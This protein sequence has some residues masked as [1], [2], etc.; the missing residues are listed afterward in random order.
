M[1]KPKQTIAERRYDYNKYIRSA[2][3]ANIKTALLKIRGNACQRCGRRPLRPE[4]HHVTY[5]RFGNENMHDLRVLCRECHTVED[6]ARADKQRRLNDAKF[7]RLCEER[8][9]HAGF[10]TWCD[11]RHVPFDGNNYEWE[12]DLFMRWIES[13]EDSYSWYGSQ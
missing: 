4:V 12:W 13:K 3:W 5:D 7:E 6:A 9:L 11:R 10:Q 8:G 2:K 1:V